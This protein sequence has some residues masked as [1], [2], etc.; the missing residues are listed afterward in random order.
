VERLVAL[1]PETT[2]ELVRAG[3][4]AHLARPRT[5]TPKNQNTSEDE[6]PTV[7]KQPRLHAFLA[8]SAAFGEDAEAVL[9]EQLLAKSVVL[10]HHSEICEY[11]RVH[12]RSRE[13][14]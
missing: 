11:L 4:E 14:I 13:I 2:N 6:K 1:M 7:S 10:A 8:A 12:R 3:L 5:T 9:R